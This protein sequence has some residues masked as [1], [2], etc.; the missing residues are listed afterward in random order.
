MPM[1]IKGAMQRSYCSTQ[2]KSEK[3]PAHFHTQLETQARLGYQ[4][5]EL[6]SYSTEIFISF[7]NIEKPK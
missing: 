6:S 5:T 7:L 1:V 3:Y 2:K 4:L